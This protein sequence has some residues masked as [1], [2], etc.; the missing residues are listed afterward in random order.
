MGARHM[1]EFTQKHW[2]RPP[3]T[4]R[5]PVAGAASVTEDPR[6]LAVSAKKYTH[7]PHT[8][9][10]TSGH[11]DA[12]RFASDAEALAYAATKGYTAVTHKH[13]S[14]A[15]YYFTDK[16]TK[17]HKPAKSTDESAWD[18]DSWI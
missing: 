8:R 18:Y 11:V 2:G 6:P 10:I 4:P 15:M 7:H 13:G 14:A 17:K 16:P 9:A 12:A 5:H 3:V 1:V